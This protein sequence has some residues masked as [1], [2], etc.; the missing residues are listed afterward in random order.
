MLG[1]NQ[2]KLPVAAG[3]LANSIA[4]VRR[5]PKR[6]RK[7]LSAAG[8]EPQP[9]TYLQ[10][11]TVVVYM[12]TVTTILHPTGLHYGNYLVTQLQKNKLQLL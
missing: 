3:T 10:I 8:F 4:P 2:Y 9:E 7:K 5:L 11:R 12:Y 1:F 6:A